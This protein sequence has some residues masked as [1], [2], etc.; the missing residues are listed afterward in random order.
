M[1]P[2]IHHPTCPYSYAIHIEI[3][4]RIVLASE[5]DWDLL[6]GKYR[7]FTKPCVQY[8]SARSCHFPRSAS[9]RILLPLPLGLELSHQFRRNV[10]SQ[11]PRTQPCSHLFV[12]FGHSMGWAFRPP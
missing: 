9:K 3:N 2:R 11:P 1:G 6:S 10:S 12:R 4:G 8:G 5:A 7:E